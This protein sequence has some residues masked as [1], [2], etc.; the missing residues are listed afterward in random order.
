M[1][2]QEFGRMRSLYEAMSVGSY[3]IAWLEEEE[4]DRSDF[5]LQFNLAKLNRAIEEF[6]EAVSQGNPLREAPQHVVQGLTF[7][8]ETLNFLTQ[9]VSERVRERLRRAGTKLQTPISLL[10]DQTDCLAERVEEILE[11][12]QISLDPQL[13][14]R[15]DSALSQIDK[16]NTEIPDWRKTLELISD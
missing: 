8:V 15:I 9:K 3:T 7:C 11:A 10:L 5:E 16:T 14:A 12:W 4:R 6:I 1:M 13:S 2:N